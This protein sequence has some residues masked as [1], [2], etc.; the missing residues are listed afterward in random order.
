[1]SGK[2]KAEEA[3]ASEV[4]EGQRI[5]GRFLV[6]R[7]KRGVGRTGKAWLQVILGDQTGSLDG[8]IWDDADAYDLEIS[9]NDVIEVEGR[10]VRFMDRIQLKILRAERITGA[11][12]DPADYLPRSER[13]ASERLEELRL[14]R[15]RMT[16]AWLRRLF[17][18]YLEDEDWIGRFL[19]APAAK[20]VHHAYVGGLSEHTLSMMALVRDIARHYETL[21][22]EPLNVDLAVMGA[23]LHDTG[24]LD[25]LSADEG[26]A[27]TDVGRLIGHITLGLD[28]LE[29]KLARIEGFPEDL[30]LHLRHLVL[31]HHGEYVYGSPRR[32]KTVE[33][34]LLHFVDNMDA[35]VEIFRQAIANAAPDGD[36]TGFEPYVDR[37]IFRRP[38]SEDEPP[39]GDLEH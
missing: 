6:R 33:A 25:E 27:Y 5:R 34:L 2:P 1:M 11:D 29:R 7:K 9:E 24:K 13:S 17:D 21:G 15:E 3:T 14:E 36:W 31:S 19:R 32:P 37:H 35:R 38:L 20:S 23:F 10:G 30:R 39:V 16:H 8:R 18:A 28:E 12:V 4:R 26:F 22:V